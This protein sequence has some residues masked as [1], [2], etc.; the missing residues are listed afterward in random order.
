MAGTLRSAVLRPWRC[1]ARTAARLVAASIEPDAGRSVRPRSRREAER[2]SWL[3]RLLRTSNVLHNPFGDRIDCG[4]LEEQ[5]IR[6]LGA[7][8]VL[9]LAGDFDDRNRIE[10]ITHKRRAKIDL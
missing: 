9:E 7:K 2:R 1:A 10:R 8:P 6:H 3:W 5:R 4:L